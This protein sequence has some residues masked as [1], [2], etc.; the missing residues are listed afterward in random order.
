MKK[1]VFGFVALF[2][3]GLA[4]SMIYQNCGGSS[5]RANSSDNDGLRVDVS[6]MDT[7]GDGIDDDGDSTGGG[8]G[9]PTGNPDFRF[10]LN[11]G[12]NFFFVTENPTTEV[13]ST[14]RVSIKSYYTIM[15]SQIFEAPSVS[16]QRDLPVQRYCENSALPHC[17][18]LLPFVCAEPGCFQGPTPVR[19]HWQRRMS[20]ADINN[21]FQALNELRFLNRNVNSQNPMIEGCN[22]PILSFHRAESDLVVS[23]ADRGCV[24][25]GSY[26]A[27]GGSGAGITTIFDAD[28]QRV[29]SSMENDVSNPEYC[30][31][32]SVYAWDTTKWTYQSRSGFV[33]QDQSYFYNVEYENQRVTM[34]YKKPGD[35]TI[36]CASGVPVQPA[37]VEVFFPTAGIPYQVF[38]TQSAIADVPTAEITYEDP[39][40][41]GAVWRFFL[42]RGSAMTNTG[43]AI[44]H[45]DRANAIANMIENV[46]VTE[47][48]RIGASAECPE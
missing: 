18:H 1:K 33:P 14:S 9:D 8:G 10:N 48:E 37:E 39:V 41:G 45:P 30:N 15:A 32:Y 34:R 42:D 25:D 22:D 28:I 38:R 40:D 36:F 20:T 2:I 6:P 43:G 21:T 31:N 44:M 26:Y 19:C 35:D 17:A 4:A 47:A 5:L 46:L 23:L 12:D 7:D 3:A 13:L 27:N 11:N 24:P 29:A 16:F